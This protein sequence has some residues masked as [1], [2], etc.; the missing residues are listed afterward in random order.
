MILREDIHI[1][2]HLSSC[3]KPEGIAADY[4]RQARE[5]NYRLIGFADHMWDSAVSGA[6]NWYVPQNL[7]HIF[8]IKKELAEAD[9]AGIEIRVGCEC[10][11]D[12]GHRDIAVAEEAAA[13][14]DFMLVPNSHTHIT[15]HDGRDDRRVH[16]EF[17]L[18]AFHDIVNSKNAKYVTAIAHPFH[19]VACPYPQ[20]E[21]QDVITDREYY[22]CYTAAA[23]AGIGIEFNPCCVGDIKE[24]TDEAMQNGD[25]FRMFSI[26]KECGCRFTFGS[27]RHTAVNYTR[28][29][30]LE[31]FIDV[32]GL[33]ESDFIS[34]L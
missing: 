25:F 24:M 33:T 4:I 26:A 17:M 29:P 9:T 31:K 18:R 32:L 22:D 23:Q 16:A 19:A 27:D 1:H 11:Y 8:E 34:I 6:P 21:L 15:F 14:L 3:G 30:K 7:E 28:Y 2:T 12:L 13:Q 20:K 10:E 5:L